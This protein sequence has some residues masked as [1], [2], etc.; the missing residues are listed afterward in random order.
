MHINENSE[1]R[2]SIAIE[3]LKYPRRKPFT[4]KF[5]TPDT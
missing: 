5:F 1:Q 4:K 2:H 3:V